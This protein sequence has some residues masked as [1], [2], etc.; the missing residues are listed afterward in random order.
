MTFADEILVSI[1]NTEMDNVEVEIVNKDK[2][3]G[4]ESNKALKLESNSI[5]KKVR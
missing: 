3:T 1:K 5:L 2:F 4:I